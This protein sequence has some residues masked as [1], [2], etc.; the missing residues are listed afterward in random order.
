M[1]GKGGREGRI[2]R[3]GD[4]GR[5]W[6]MVNWGMESKKVNE[7]VLSWGMERKAGNEKGRNRGKELLGKRGK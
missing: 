5:W 4:A 1:K 6:Q 3:V 2:L 7:D